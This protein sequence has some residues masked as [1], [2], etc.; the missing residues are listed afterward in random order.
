MRARILD[1]LFR[2]S[3]ITMPIMIL[4]IM[5]AVFAQDGMGI[6]EVSILVGFTVAWGGMWWFAKP[7]PTKEIDSLQTFQDSLKAAGRPTLIELYSSYCMACL[8][9][10]PTV[11]QLETEAGERLQIVRLDIDKEPGKQLVK[12]YN[13]VFTPTF[14]HF[15]KEGKKVRE[16]TMVLDRPRIL[17]DL[18]TA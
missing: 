13:V 6:V 17:Y 8:A 16:S 1:I 10:K 11:E 14:I 7:S 9:M 3:V 5:A 18:E 2:R 15:D 12:E 4:A